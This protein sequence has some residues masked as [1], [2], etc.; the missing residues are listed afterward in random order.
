MGKN[1]IDI[2]AID[3]EQVILDSIVK[4]GRMEG[5]EVDTSDNGLSAIEKLNSAD[6][7]LV[8]SD[9]MMPVMDGFKLLEEL[10]LRNIPTPVIMTT[11]FSTFENALNSLYRGAIDFIP[12]PFSV[13]EII[14]ILKRGLKY[15]DIINPP[16]NTPRPAEEITYVPCPSKYHRLG[17]SG[18][19][20]CAGRKSVVTGVTDLFNKTIDSIMKIEL[21]EAGDHIA[22]ANYALKIETENNMI[23]QLYSPI[24]GKIIARNEKLLEDFSLLE[25]DP[26]FEGWIYQIEPIDFENEIKNLIP[27]CS[28]RV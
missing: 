10:S 19:V 26:Y 24:S 4:I 13:E 9:L 3:D 14:S 12:K 8:I 11:G 6:Y 25:K 22:Q 2:L 18:W 17:Y 16:E 23:H 1:I 20:Y 15:A 28:D 7:R 27:C 5:L 21:I